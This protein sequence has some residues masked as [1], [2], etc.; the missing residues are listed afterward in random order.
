MKNFIKG[1]F[2]PS[3][4]FVF[5]IMAFI[6]LIIT[7]GSLFESGII[8]AMAMTVLEIKDAKALIIEKNDEIFSLVETESRAM[9]DEETAD[10][11][12]NLKKI[13]DLDLR[14]E[15]ENRKQTGSA[16]QGFNIIKPKEPFSLIQAIRSKVEMREMPRSARELF[17]VGKESF[18]KAGLSTYGDLFI[19]ATEK[20]EKR[21]DILAGTATA[22]QEIVQEDKKAIMPPLTDNMVL[23][24]A[25]ATYMPNLVGNVSIPGYAGTTV[26]WKTEVEA[27]ADGGGA[28]TEVELSPNR[29]TAYVNV[30]KTFLAQDGVGAERLLLDNIALATA[31]KLQ[32]TILGVA[33]GSSSVPS[34][35][36]YKITTGAQEAG[37]VPTWALL[38]AVIAGI[39]LANA[40]QGKIG[41]ITNATGRGV[42]RGIAQN[43]A[44][45]DF[46]YDKDGKVLG[47]PC[48]ITNSASAAAGTAGTDDLLVFGNWADLVIGQWGG[49]DITVD[50]YTMA[51]TNQVQI[52][53]NAYFDAKGLRG[54]TGAGATLDEYAY[55]FKSSAIKAS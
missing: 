31:L 15:S 6:S 11:E 23:F 43:G 9:T 5:V 47:Y 38:N 30:S 48:F 25:G 26:A 44:G 21:A 35:M 41:W 3:T 29:L 40:L 46:L 16:I 14:M 52:V 12:A 4:L 2:N 24:A 18:L 7:N 22:G 17:S 51:K 53:I 32:S 42:L 34:G 49:Y 33:I 55:S 1:F 10:I 8:T 37:F 50:P 36:G 45:S 27:A 20:N 28:F 19:P 54:V 39:D 13:K